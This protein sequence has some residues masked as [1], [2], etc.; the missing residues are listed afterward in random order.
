MK[1]RA[2]PAVKK[3]GGRL[4]GMLR[5]LPRAIGRVLSS[6]RPGVINVMT[7]RPY[8]VLV[9]VVLIS[10]F[11]T[12]LV[13]RVVGGGGTD[14]G[15]MQKMMQDIKESKG[16]DWSI[17]SATQTIDGTTFRLTK[18][19]SDRVCFKSQDSLVWKQEGCIFYSQVV[20]VLPVDTQ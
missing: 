15:S 19:E 6:S 17:R 1:D 10:V 5:A 18:V 3:S 13:V 14:Y 9:A 7:A 16:T 4:L 20:I 11:A 2:L 12:L 8:I